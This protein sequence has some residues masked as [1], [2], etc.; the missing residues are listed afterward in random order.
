[1]VRVPLRVFRAE[2]SLRLEQALDKAGVAVRKSWRNTNSVCATPKDISPNYVIV[3]VKGRVSIQDPRLSHPS[4]PH[5]VHLGSIDV[6]SKSWPFYAAELYVNTV[7]E[8][9]GPSSDAVNQGDAEHP[10]EWTPA[11]YL[12]GTIPGLEITRQGG[13]RWA[14]GNKVEWNLTRPSKLRIGRS[15]EYVYLPDVVLH[16]FSGPPPDPSYRAV[17]KDFAMSKGGEEWAV[18]NLVWSRQ[19]PH[20]PRLTDSQVNRLF[21]SFAKGTSM[22]NIAVELH[23]SATSISGILRGLSHTDKDSLRRWCLKQREKNAISE[24]N[25]VLEMR[26]RLDS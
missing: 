2:D 15:T 9:D 10:T 17:L 5:L 20:R 4:V 12:E 1:M 26:K 19:R 14:N 21:E 13:A 22:A 7:K 18:D 11:V 23:V 8:K 16:T 24:D 3:D 6:D 25:T